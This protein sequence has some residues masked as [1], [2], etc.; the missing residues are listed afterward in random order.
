MKYINTFCEIIWKQ[1]HIWLNIVQTITFYVSNHN[2]FITMPVLLSWSSF[3]KI[4]QGNKKST[5]ITKTTI[6][7]YELFFQQ[8]ERMFGPVFK[9]R[10]I[11]LFTWSHYLMSHLGHFSPTWF[12]QPTFGY[13]KSLCV[14]T[15]LHRLK[16]W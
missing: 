2:I 11:S 1:F 12:V 4:I 6:L 9:R 13:Q 10:N 14:F 5:F 16:H 8:R 3:S 15:N 7:L